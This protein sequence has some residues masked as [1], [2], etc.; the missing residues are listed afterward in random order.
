MQVNPEQ[1]LKKSTQKFIK[2]FAYIENKVRQ[3][4]REVKT[5]E[6]AELDALWD[7]AKEVF[8][9]QNDRNGKNDNF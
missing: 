4:G 5:C 3:S 2:R 1:A 6:L 9:T 7:E 8:K